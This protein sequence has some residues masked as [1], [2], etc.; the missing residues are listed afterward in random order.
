MKDAILHQRCHTHVVTPLAL[1]AT[2]EFLWVTF[3]CRLI[4]YDVVNE[5]L[6]G[7]ATVPLHLFLENLVALPVVVIG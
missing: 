6:V 4:T 1:D 2:P 7:G 5:F 3:A